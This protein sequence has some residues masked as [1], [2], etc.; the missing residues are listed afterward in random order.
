MPSHARK[1][2]T[3]ETLTIALTR[4]L[5]IGTAALMP[6]AAV[7]PRARAASDLRSTLLGMAEAHPGRVGIGVRD[8]ST[9]TTT[10]VGE[11]R[12][13]P[14]QSVYKFPIGLAVL[15]A[16]DRGDLR[17]D[18]VVPLGPADMSVAW[19]PLRDRLKGAPG[20]ATV[21]ELLEQM[22]AW[23]D[24]TAC[25]VLMR[26]VG[27]PGA[28][29]DFL[30]GKGITAIRIDRYERELQPQVYGLDWRPEFVDPAV[31]KAALE[32][33]GRDARMA[34][35]AAWLDDPRDTCTPEGM[36][37]LL[38]AFETG[39]MVSDASTRVMR[40]IL[41]GTVTG[42]KRLKAGVP[43]G[44]RVGHKTG[45]GF[46]MDGVSSAA[47]DVGLLYGPNGR[48][49]AV[50]V[51]TAGSGSDEAARDGLMAAVARAATA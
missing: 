6:L 51:F 21:R 36:L 40:D 27:G 4:R 16:V 42:A 50:A 48:I 19:S 5:I 49:L 45:T 30:K 46:T 24:N 26:M 43:D 29:T 18:Q 47:N 7:A 22:V 13:F 15:D 9:G 38:A 39:R 23:S 25:D 11:G 8:L 37:D 3:E 12:R 31:F 10:L 35:L 1:T 41:L 44:W 2:L 17:L 33:R 34:A 28:V 20:E 32:A 14:M